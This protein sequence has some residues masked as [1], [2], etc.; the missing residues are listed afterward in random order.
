MKKGNVCQACAVPDRGTVSDGN[1]ADA[2]ETG[3]GSHYDQYDH[4]C[5]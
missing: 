1:D 5:R 2:A 4:V 3:A